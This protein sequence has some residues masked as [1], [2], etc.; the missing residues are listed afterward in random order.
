MVFL[1]FEINSNILS[2]LTVCLFNVL[3]LAVLR[4][5]CQSICTSYNIHII[6]DKKRVLT[7][8]QSRLAG[9]FGGPV[10]YIPL[11]R[12]LAFILIVYELLAF[13]LDFSINGTSRI[14]H[15]PTTYKSLVSSHP[16]H[17]PL[18]I[19][20]ANEYNVTM[21]RHNIDND[22]DDEESGDDEEEDEDD[23]E[24]VYASQ[25]LVA[26]AEVQACKQLNF[27]HHTNHAFA[28]KS[29]KLSS[30]ELVPIHSLVEG[31]TCVTVRPSLTEHKGGFEKDV[32]THSFAQ[33]KPDIRCSHW[34]GVTLSLGNRM[35]VNVDRRSSGDDSD[36]QEEDEEDDRRNVITPSAE[37]CDLT[38]MASDTVC[39]ATLAGID[40]DRCNIDFQTVI[41]FHRH[42]LTA[43]SSTSARSS[44]STNSNTNS[45]INNATRCA[46]IGHLRQ[47]TSSNTSST[48][49]DKVL[50]ITLFEHPFNFS[51]SHFIPSS[52][53]LPDINH[54]LPVYYPHYTANVAFLSAI[55][56]KYGFFNS[57]FMSVAHVQYNVTLFVTD[58]VIITEVDSHYVVPALAVVA[59][60]LVAL[61]CTA[62]VLR[63]KFVVKPGRRNFVSF[64]NVNEVFNVEKGTLAA[65]RAG[66]S[67][68]RYIVLRDSVPVFLNEL[69][70]TQ[71]EGKQKPRQKR[72]GKGN[73]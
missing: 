59:L 55:R 69:P 14:D 7:P 71:K 64:S 40:P 28:Y 17:L 12:F 60:L 3:L 19:D 44:S 6:H 34:D 5:V 65:T 20:Y 9:L 10:G 8:Q 35:N 46:A 27:T 68:K 38:T 70:E 41:C 37:R 23:G 30:T 61:L 47:S 2:G 42:S 58:R 50:T 51:S 39:N 26:I 45:D 43:I 18:V 4:L 24:I 15:M 11:S 66:K 72:K 36:G 53:V 62:F 49:D 48:K 56:V 33:D 67:S 16:K 54:L 29:V 32:A 22:D 21:R 63:I 1:K 25:R 57:L 13:L 31:A 52:F 73:G